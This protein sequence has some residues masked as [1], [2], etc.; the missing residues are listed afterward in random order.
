MGSIRPYLHGPVSLID[1]I[2]TVFQATEVERTAVGENRF[3]VEFQMGDS[4]IVLEAGELPD[5]I[6]PWINSIY[7][8]VEDV[9]GA[10]ERALALDAQIL[11]P[12]QDKPYQERQAGFKDVAGYTWWVSR[13]LA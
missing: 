12:P 3:H 2:T 1:F 11:Q 6:E 10:F 13:F 4:I 5:V 8:Y 7:V 9:D